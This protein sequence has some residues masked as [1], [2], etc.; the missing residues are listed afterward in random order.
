MSDYRIRVSL[1]RTI[2]DS[3]DYLIRNA[4]TENEALRTLSELQQVAQSGN[5]M[6]VKSDKIGVHP[7]LLHPDGTYVPEH[8]G[9]LCAVYVLEPG[10]GDEVMKFELIDDRGNVVR[11]LGTVKAGD[12]TIKPT[13]EMTSPETMDSGIVAGK[14]L[15]GFDFLAFKDGNGKDCS[16]QKSSVATEDYVWLGCDKIGLVMEIPGVGFQDIPTESEGFGGVNYLAN[17]RMHL[18]RRQVGNLIPHLQKFVQ[19][20]ELSTPTPPETP[21]CEDGFRIRAFRERVSSTENDYLVTGVSTIEEAARKLS[22]EQMKADM[23]RKWTPSDVDGIVR[24]EYGAVVPR[25]VG[26]PVTEDYKGVQPLELPEIEESF[27]FVQIDKYGEPIR[28]LTEEI[29]CRDVNLGAAG[30]PL[31]IDWPDVSEFTSIMEADEE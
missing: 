29:P 20:G 9:K 11:E 31:D 12:G 2:Y 1:E 5:M 15:R 13:M 16:L 4:T 21:V 28:H 26:I 24:L 7:L 22:R 8:S 10:G 19:T 30:E 23:S 17:T 3:N 14:T 6:V 25:D 27:G 18:N